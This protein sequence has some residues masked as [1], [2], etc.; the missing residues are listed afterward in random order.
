MYTRMQRLLF[1]NHDGFNISSESCIRYPCMCEDA[2]EKLNKLFL[3][4]CKCFERD[5]RSIHFRYEKNCY[6][7]RGIKYHNFERNGGDKK[8]REKWKN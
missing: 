7:K 6:H 5:E 1:G 8:Q 4:R 2:N 3:Y